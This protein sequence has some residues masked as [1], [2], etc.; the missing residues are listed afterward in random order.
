MKTWL[1]YNNLTMFNKFGVFGHFV[2]LL[3]ETRKNC[4][5]QFLEHQICYPVF[6]TDISFT[7]RLTVKA[8]IFFGKELTLR[9]TM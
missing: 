4:R 2:S 5:K 8:Q 1:K 6:V 3:F 7:I 9:E